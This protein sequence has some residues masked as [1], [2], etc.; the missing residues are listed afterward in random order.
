MWRRAFETF[1]ELRGPLLG[2][3][4]SRHV[5]SML[6]DSFQDIVPDVLNTLYSLPHAMP[7]P[8]LRDSLHLAYRAEYDLTGHYAWKMELGHADRDLRTAL[9]V[10]EDLGAIKRHEGMAD[11]VFLDL[12][13]EESVLPPAGMPPELAELFGAVA[14]GQRESEDA[15]ERSKEQRAEL[16]GGPVELIRLTALGHDSVR[17]RLLTEGVMP[18][19]SVNSPTPPPPG[20]SAS[21]PSTTTRT[22]PA[23]NSLP[24]SPP[25]RALPRRW[26][27]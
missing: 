23:P 4:S 26:R 21:S 14:G 19:S 13:L 5:E 1:S 3:R 11:P 8:R 10:L 20:S 22:P 27:S 12:P 16:T 2:T 7:W 9:D 25:G 15:E 17:R 18:R 6:F 24:G